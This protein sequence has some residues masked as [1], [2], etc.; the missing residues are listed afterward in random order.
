MPIINET[1]GGIIFFEI[2][3]IQDFKKVLIDSEDVSDS[4]ENISVNRSSTDTLS[5]CQ[6]TL[7]NDEGRF[8]NKWNGGETI[9]IWIDN[10]DGNTTKQFTGKLDSAYKGLTNHHIMVIG[11]RDRPELMNH[12]TFDFDGQNI[13]DALKSVIDSINT[14]HGYNVITYSGTSIEE[15]TIKVLRDGKKLDLKAKLEEKI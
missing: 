9:E 10:V 8:N 12:G 15:I 3:D 13:D 2:E 7:F 4:V 5:S 6:V 11:G 14:R 1:G